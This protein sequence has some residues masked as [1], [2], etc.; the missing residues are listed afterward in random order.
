LCVAGARPVV[1]CV[2]D[3]SPAAV[4]SVAACVVETV[5]PVAFGIEYVL[6][7]NVSLPT[8]A[9]MITVH[10][11]PLGDGE[12]PGDF[13]DRFSV[14][15]ATV[16]DGGAPLTCES[17]TTSECIAGV[18]AGGTVTENDA[19]PTLA[20]ACGSNDEEPPPWHASPVKMTIPSKTK[21]R[22]LIHGLYV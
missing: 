7:V 17:V 12:H 8:G 14:T 1:V 11:K 3:A 21:N 22:V 4:I 6:I 9:L 10:R 19:C 18:V 20:G 2:H 5:V 16:E 13:N 15:G